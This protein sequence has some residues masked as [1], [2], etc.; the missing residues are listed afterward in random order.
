MED[1][2][3][4]KTD[5]RGASSLSVICARRSGLRSDRERLASWAH[6]GANSI[7]NRALA[8][9]FGA[10]CRVNHVQQIC[11][12]MIIKDLVALTG[13]EQVTGRF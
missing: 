9:L 12:Y 1:P 10:H 4:A 2:E 8:P 13:I 11:K 6:H 5:R 7:W 3:C